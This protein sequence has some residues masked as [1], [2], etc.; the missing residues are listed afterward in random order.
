MGGAVRLAGFLIWDL[1]RSSRAWRDLAERGPV[2]SGSLVHH[3]DR[4]HYRQHCQC[5]P[6]HV[7]ACERISRTMFVSSM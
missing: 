1:R 3:L 7:A 4:D 5:R 6:F 2:Q